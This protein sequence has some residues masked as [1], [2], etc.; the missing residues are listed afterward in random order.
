M[1]THLSLVQKKS[2]SKSQSTVKSQCQLATSSTLEHR[3]IS[4]IETAAQVLCHNCFTA[5]ECTALGLAP[6]G[7]SCN[8]CFLISLLPRLHLFP[9]IQKA[10]IAIDQLQGRLPE[11]SVEKASK[12]ELLELLDYHSSFLLEVE[13]QLSSLGLLKQHTVSMLQDVEV[14]PPSQEELPVIQEIKA[15]QDRCHK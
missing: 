9:Q 12:T 15:M 1:R 3:F 7:I 2:L 11:S 10:T 14:K 8:S 6:F 4:A 5:S 13:H